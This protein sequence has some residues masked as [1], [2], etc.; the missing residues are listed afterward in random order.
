MVCPV[1][2]GDQTWMGLTE[3]CFNRR[4]SALTEKTD[5]GILDRW[6]LLR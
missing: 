1:T 3:Q 2:E 4:Y 6:S 5:C